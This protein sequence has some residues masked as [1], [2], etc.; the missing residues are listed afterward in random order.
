MKIDFY[1][2]LIRLT[3]LFGPWFLAF[4]SH[5]IGV[6]YFFFS[7][8]RRESRRLYAI[9]FP[10]KN[11]LHHLWCA[12]RQYQNFTTIHFDRFLADRGEETRFT[13]HGWDRLQTVIGRTGGILLMSHL[14]NWEIAARLLKEQLPGQPFLLYM[15]IKEKE[16][17]ERR[18]KEELSRSGITIIGE[19]REGGSPFSAVEGV[20]FLRSG[21]LV[22]MTGD[23]V[24]RPDQRKVRVSFLGGS[25]FLPEAP[26]V[27]A[28]V[29]GAPIFAFFAFRTGRNSYRITLSDPITLPSPVS[30]ADRDQVIGKAAQ[31]YALLLE[32]ALRDHPLEWYHF[33]RFIE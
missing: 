23:I 27:F 18:Q 25:A 19:P 9:L 12:F 15:G 33:D 26:F 31:E 32:K 16:G 17:V 13:S 8:R 3:R 2:T 5:S 29:S 7:P 14:G 28:L 21:G 4:I 11:R 30:K 22:S 6:G 1:G 20:R 10:E 24:W